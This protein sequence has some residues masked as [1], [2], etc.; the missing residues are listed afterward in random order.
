MDRLKDYNISRQFHKTRFKERLLEHFTEAQE[1]YDGRKTLIAFSKSMRTIL[2]DALENRSFSED[3]LTLAKVA[4]IIREDI[5]NRDNVKFTGNFPQN[6]L[7]DSLPACLKLLIS[8]IFN[9]TNLKDQDRHETQAC[10]TVCQAIV[11]NTKKIA[12]SSGVKTR[13]SSDHEPPL[14]I[15]I[16][17]NIHQMA[18]SKKLIQ[19]L[20]HLGICISYN[21]VLE[22]EDGI[23]ASVSVQFEEEGVVAPSCL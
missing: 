5:F 18:R 2:R 17:V 3:A 8:L 21:R 10:L 9:G 7:E 4:K 15:Y 1:Q 13:H 12:S 14:P 6:C 23:A 16:G 22:I 11:F 19:Q 20:Y